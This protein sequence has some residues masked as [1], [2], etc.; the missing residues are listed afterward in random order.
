MKVKDVVVRFPYK[1]FRN[2]VRAADLENA[3]E[4][5]RR[6]IAKLVATHGW[7][8][9]THSQAFTVLRHYRYLAAATKRKKK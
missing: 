7:T 5:I 9:K 6:W 8:V 2:A 3:E 4:I 1:A